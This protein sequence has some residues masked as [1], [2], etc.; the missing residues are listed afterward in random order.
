MISV[1]LNMLCDEV[2]LCF[3]MLMTVHEQQKKRGTN[4]KGIKVIKKYIFLQFL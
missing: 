2:I 3:L 4:E 1:V